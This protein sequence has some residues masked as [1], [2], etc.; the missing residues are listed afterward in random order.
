MAIRGWR[1]LSKEGRNGG[2]SLRR[3]KPTE[4]V[5]E[6]EQEECILYFPPY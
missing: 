5:G 6:Q 3:L 1:K 2:E 4:E